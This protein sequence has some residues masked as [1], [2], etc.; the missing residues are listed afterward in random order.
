MLVSRTSEMTNTTLRMGD[1]HLRALH[2]KYWLWGHNHRAM[3]AQVMQCPVVLGVDT[4]A[5]N[6]LDISILKRRDRIWCVPTPEPSLLTTFAVRGQFIFC[7]AM[8]TFRSSE[9]HTG[10]LHIYGFGKRPR[11]AVLLLICVL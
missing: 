5:L 2:C 11:F 1:A 6:P 9:S 7:N 3:P 4:T 8:V 10:L